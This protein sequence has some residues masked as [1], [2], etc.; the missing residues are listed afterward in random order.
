[1]ASP[2]GSGLTWRVILDEPGSGAHN[3]ALD[4]ALAM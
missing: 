4:H 3:M 1:M 2:D